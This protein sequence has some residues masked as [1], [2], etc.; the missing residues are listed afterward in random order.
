LYG[1]FGR[2]VAHSLSPAIHNAAFEQLGVDAAYVPLAAADLDDVFEALSVVDVSGASVTAPFKEGVMPRLAG[3]DG[4]AKSVGA[5]NTLVRRDGGWYGCNTDTVGFLEGCSGTPMAGRRVAVLGTGGAAR[6]VATAASRAGA[7]VT[8][9][10]R[11]RSRTEA[12]AA[13]LAVGGA[14]RPVPPGSWDILVNATPVGTHPDS[15][16]SAFPEAVY[17]GSLAY[18]LVYNP[19]QTRFLREA[20][21]AGCRPVGG[22]DMLIAQAVRQVERW[23]G[24]TP[25][26]ISMREA[27]ELALSRQAAQT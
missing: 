14:L 6:A 10:G 16:E 13:A 11:D 5:V 12:L 3:I 24:R 19:P 2:P 1:I 15:E 23:T 7:S 18:D 4:D 21:A 20:A 22:L 26:P 8:C 17:D 25:E 9:Y 27:A